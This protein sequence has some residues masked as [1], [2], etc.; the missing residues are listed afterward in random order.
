MTDPI[1]LADT[2]TP[3]LTQYHLEYKLTAS[4]LGCWSIGLTK[5]EMPM[6]YY[7]SKE[8]YAG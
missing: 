6:Q 8:V 4:C 2:P 3:D 5:R 7:K 1:L